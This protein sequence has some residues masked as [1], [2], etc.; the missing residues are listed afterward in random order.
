[1]KAS[2]PRAA[3]VQVISHPTPQRE[4]KPLRS[5]PAKNHIHIKKGAP[6]AP[7]S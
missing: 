3:I 6:K 7:L 2:G 1:V 5:K 4:A